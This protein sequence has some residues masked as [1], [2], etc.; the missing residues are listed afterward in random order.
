MNK[1]IKVLAFAMLAL[2]SCKTQEQAVKEVI[3]EKDSINVSRIETYRDSTIMSMLKKESQKNAIIVSYS[4]GLM[5]SDTSIVSTEFVK[6]LAWVQGGKLFHTI[7]T[8]KEQMP[9]FVPNAIKEVKTEINR[10]KSK[11]LIK[12]I[13]IHTTTNILTK[14]QRFF[15]ALGYC[16]AG[17]ILAAMVYFAC[18]L[19]RRFAPTL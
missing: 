8:T 3:R 13:T 16:F 9:V 17:V 15:I 6:S 19:K 14:T 4:N 7:E 2:F 11:S 1:N 18:R 10:S 12:T 5:N